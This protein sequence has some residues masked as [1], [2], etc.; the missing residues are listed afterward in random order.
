MLATLISAFPGTGKSYYF[1]KSMLNVLD[2][3]SNT[4]D[5]SEFPTNYINHIKNNIEKVDCILISSHRPVRDALVANNLEFVLVY[6]DKSLR[7]EYIKRYEERGSNK[8]FIALL[9]NNWDSWIDELINQKNCS[10][11]VLQSGEYLSN[12][13]M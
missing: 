6:P 3:D 10:H 8:Q 1:K 12:Y 2:S 4:F 13:F 11:I 7:D 9:T 5:K